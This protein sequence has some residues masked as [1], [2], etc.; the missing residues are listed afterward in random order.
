LICAGLVLCCVAIYGQTLVHD[1][2]L[3]D[4]P[5]YVTQNSEVQAGLNWDNLGWAFTTDR[6]MYMHPLTWMSHMLDC[7]LYG[8][9]PWGHHLTNLLLHALGTVLLF[10]VLSRM[11]GRAWPSA[12]A[13]A[14]FAVHPLHVES[15][16]WIAER[17]DVLSMVFWTAGLGAYAW[18]RQRPSV[19]RYLATAALF[20]LGFM[21]KPMVVTFPFVLLLLDYWPLGRVDRTAPP[22]AMTRQLARLAWEKTP[23]FLLTAA[24]C[25]VTLA[26]QLRANNLEFMAKVPFVDRCA[27][28][29]VVYA[30]YLVKTVWPSGLAVYYPHPIT[31][32]EWQV[33]GAAL[34][35]FA[36]T[37]V[38]I[39]QFRRRPYLIVGWCWYLGTLVPVIELVQAGTFSHA[40]RYTYIP[41]IGIFI[42]AAWG[43]DELRQ[44]RRI[45][46]AAVTCAAAVMVA[47][48]ML[49]AAIQTGH[50]KN[51]E[52][53]YRHALEV[54]AE[55]S[56]SRYN[57]GAGLYANKKREEALG[58]FQRALALDPANV[59]AIEHIAA[60]LQ[61]QED[62][63]AAAARHREALMLAPEFA[64]AHGNLKNALKKLN[65]LDALESERGELLK[66]QAKSL[67]DLCRLG[68]ISMT[69]G[70]V[71][72]AS[73]F[74]D[75]S[76]KMEPS[77]RKT[78]LAI[79]SVLLKDKLYDKA[80]PFYEK[81]LQTTPNDPYAL[82]NSGLIL[83]A[84]NRS[85][86]AADKYRAALRLNP[87]FVPAHNNL[88]ILLADSGH[89]DEAVEH[90]LK[91]IALVPDSRQARINLASLLMENHRNA[92]AETQLKKVLE[93]DPSNA[94]A[95]KLMS[96]FEADKSAAPASE[97]KEP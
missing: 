35:L 77:G 19:R 91:V 61:D 63:E 53:L 47:G 3:Y 68:V 46:A 10:L 32:P 8:L 56:F 62:Y 7:D 28:A 74:F 13:A 88:G 95:L 83:T 50:W 43:L 5:L 42:M 45:P 6:A 93:A 78:N 33:A 94:E 11:T 1:F 54:T 58:Q 55:S 85:A 17:K 2:I 27:N 59:L 66:K 76:R 21:S 49:A 71:N 26:M 75:Q 86:E 65:T 51:N 41:L 57:F 92:E 72:E 81:A 52:T 18:H 90:F 34:V 14:L 96:Q 25:A 9:R 97:H 4:D 31:R 64:M 44:S 79:G 82:Y 20:L 29:L 39:W 40:D 84:L 80:L 12:L 16:A 87:D 48:F 69:L 37:M 23:L 67:D 24:M 38:S 36:V 60:L 70:D 30:L 89:L 22:G 73:A 15:V